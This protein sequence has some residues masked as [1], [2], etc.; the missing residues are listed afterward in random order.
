MTR[1]RDHTV[2]QVVGRGDKVIA[3]FDTYTEAELFR[4]RYGSPAARVK[5][6]RV[7]DDPPPD[8]GNGGTHGE[9]H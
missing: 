9:G 6:V 4:L 3:S 8:A 1:K 5:V 7:D 2:Y